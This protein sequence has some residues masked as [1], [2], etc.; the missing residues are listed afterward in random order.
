M[1]WAMLV[2]SRFYGVVRY[3]FLNSGCICG[4]HALLPAVGALVGK[5]ERPSRWLRFFSSFVLASFAAELALLVSLGSVRSR[6]LLGPGF[7]VAHVILFLI[8]TPA[9]AVRLS[10]TIL[11]FNQVLSQLVRELARVPSLTTSDP[12]VLL[13][14][15]RETKPR[16]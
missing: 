7:Y 5:F 2:G 10:H 9:L 8:G 16:R 3:R 11:L 4:Q 12:S 13:N 1:K 14:N 15:S 6:S